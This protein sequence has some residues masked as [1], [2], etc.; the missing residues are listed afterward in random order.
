MKKP[1][2]R[3]EDVPLVLSEEGDLPVIV[4]ANQASISA[5][6][7]INAK[8][9]TDDHNISFALQNES[10]SFTTGEVRTFLMGPIGGPAIQLPESVEI[11]QS[12]QKIAY[13]NGA[14]LYVNK[15]VHAGEYHIEVKSSGD[16]SLDLTEKS[17]CLELILRIQK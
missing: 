10:L 4:F 3:Y 5:S 8:K 14:A 15:D 13:P 17:R 16:I 6:Q 2:F 9:F 1:F 11:I 7:S 12:G